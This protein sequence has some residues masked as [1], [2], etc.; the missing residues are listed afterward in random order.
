MAWL[1]EHYDVVEVTKDRK[2]YV[3]YNRNM[4]FE[5]SRLTIDQKVTFADAYLVKC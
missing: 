3:W 1:N 2:D 4:V 5:V